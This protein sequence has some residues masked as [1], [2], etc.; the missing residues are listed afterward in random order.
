MRDGMKKGMSILLSALLLFSLVACSDSGQVESGNQDY[1]ITAETAEAKGVCGADLTWYYQDNVLVIKGTGEMI[2][3]SSANSDRP[4]WAEYADRISWVI[5]ENGVT[6]IGGY[7][8]DGFSML[9]KVEMPNSIVNI[10]NRAFGECYRLANIPLSSSLETIGKEAFWHCETLESVTLPEGLRVVNESAFRNCYALRD[11]LLP[12]SLEEIG[13]Y[14]FAYCTS[15]E[16]I[17]IPSSVK[18]MGNYVFIQTDEDPIKQITF[19]GNTPELQKSNYDWHIFTGLNDGSTIIYSGNGF[20]EHIEQCPQYNWV[21]KTA[22]MAE[23]QTELADSEPDDSL[24]EKLWREAYAAF[25]RNGDYR[26][27]FPDEI[28]YELD[29]FLH[30]IDNNGIP[31]LIIAQPAYENIAIFTYTSTVSYLSSQNYHNYAEIFIPDNPVYTGLFISWE[32]W[33][34]GEPPRTYY[35][36]VTINNRN[37]EVDYSD[38]SY[39]EWNSI[40]KKEATVYTINA[41]NIQKYIYGLT[42]SAEPHPY[43]TALQE[44]FKDAK[45]ETAAYL[46]DVNGDGVDEMLAVK[47]P[48]YS[49]EQDMETRYRL[50]YIYNGTLYTQDEWY[51]D[52]SLY[53]SSNNHLISTGGGVEICIHLLIDEEFKRSAVIL[54]GLPD[55]GYYTVNGKEISEAEYEAYLKQYGLDQ[56]VERVDETAK[57]LAIYK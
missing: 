48:T 21:K 32:Q 45:G 38:I 10:G 13:S 50:F 6:S 57:I 26:E 42:D 18:I 14:G 52:G 30:D 41:S 17:T 47:Y 31:E 33:G 16:S 40:S 29:F 19:E 49:S 28:N 37:G 51:M 11:V 4:S 7:S 25:L 56:Y 15:L 36:H 20:E 23:V 39:S 22:N 43:A 44:F 3:H 54:Y 34:G 55:D 24:L 2:D 5:I 8:F 53:L 35:D 9:T 12:S 1:G 27:W 46:A